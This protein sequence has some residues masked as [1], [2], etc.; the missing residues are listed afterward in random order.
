MLTEKQLLAMPAEDY[1]NEAQVAFFKALLEE[2]ARQ[3]IARLD[4]EGETL[5]LQRQA[6]AADSASSEEA[7]TLKL[8]MDQKDR[9]SL[10]Q[11]NRALNLI[12]TGDYGYCL[13]TGE[14]IGLKRLLLLPESVYTVETM[15]V[16]E[17]K[18]SHQR[19]A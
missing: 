3:I 13:E 19:A 2:K 1:M 16:I 10:L 6:D 15:R 17:A 18:S 8:S 14:E 12:E 9:A 4:G 5:L 11:V 7:M